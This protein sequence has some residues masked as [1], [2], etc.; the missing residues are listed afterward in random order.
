MRW[1]SALALAWAA[2]LSCTHAS[3]VVAHEDQRPPPL[4]TRRLDQQLEGSSLRKLID[5]YTLPLNVPSQWAIH[6]D[7]QSGFPYYHN[8]ETGLTQWENPWL[9]EAAP[10]QELLAQLSS[11]WRL[12]ELFQ[13]RGLFDDLTAIRY[14]R[15]LPRSLPNADAMRHIASVAGLQF[16]V[17]QARLEVAL[18]KAEHRATPSLSLDEAQE[19]P[20]SPVPPPLD[21]LE[22]LLMA[23]EQEEAPLEHVA[24]EA[25]PKESSLAGIGDP[26]LGTHQD[27]R[28]ALAGGWND[29]AN[30]WYARGEW[31]LA[32]E[33]FRRSLFWNPEQTA[34]LI[35]LASALVRLGFE[36]DAAVVWDY[37]VDVEGG[38]MGGWDADKEDSLV[39]SIEDGIKLARALP[40]ADGRTLGE[41]QLRGVQL[42]E[43][44]LAIAARKVTAGVFL[45]SLVDQEAEDIAVS[46]RDAGKQH[47]S[48]KLWSSSLAKDEDDS[49]LQLSALTDETAARQR[50]EQIKGEP[51]ASSKDSSHARALSDYAASTTVRL[52]QEPLNVQ[53]VLLRSSSGQ[54]N[55]STSG[56]FNEELVLEWSVVLLLCGGL[57]W[58]LWRAC[59]PTRKAKHR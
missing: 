48:R 36:R 28:I 27:T 47:S 7:P 42:R 5:Q 6:Y 45:Q 26:P 34:T 31:E 35:N 18:F 21:G 49:V 15:N 12:Y 30:M 59:L 56:W 4:P 33:S 46:R 13:F 22:E 58:A 24:T 53:T 1:T 50:I 29:L 44:D 19:A 32:I 39:S 11:S 3:S 9:E 16:D 10:Q 14:R 2:W 38:T 43:A 54:W 20:E 40:G 41:L 23:A 8:T 17:A 57:G 37:Y 25:P 55:P 52:A 51:S